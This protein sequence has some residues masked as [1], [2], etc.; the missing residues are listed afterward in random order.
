[1]R[2]RPER[3]RPH[4]AFLYGGSLAFAR[5]FPILALLAA[6]WLLSPQQFGQL[7][8][9]V[10]AVTTASLL[11]DSGT[12]SAATWHASRQSETAS[13]AR[14]LAALNWLRIAAATILTAGLTL[15]QI[16]V[17]GA[18]NWGPTIAAVLIAVAAN[19]LSARNGVHRVRLR[20]NGVGEPRSLLTE[21]LTGGLLF[22]ALVWPVSAMPEY[23]PVTYSATA[24]AGAL[25]V[26]KRPTKAE[27]STSFLTLVGF[28][29]IASPFMISALCAAV[30]WRA[31]TFVLGS[32]GDVAAAG[33]LAL[34]IYPI[35]LLTTVPVLTAPL[36]L[37]RGG[38]HSK[39]GRS[40]VALGA[41]IAFIASLALAGVLLI[42]I[43]W[44]PIQIVEEPVVV[45]LLILCLCIMPLWINPLVSSW[46][47]GNVSVWFPTL[48]HILGALV[49]IALVFPAA[50]G[51]SAAGAA[52]VIVTSEVT[53]LAALVCVAVIT[54]RGKAGRVE[55]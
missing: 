38:E 18:S 11:A 4:R 24:L 55:N 43:N 31:P 12:D 16:N 49:A 51:W 14:A 50:H 7:A 39:T 37:V 34:A 52:A 41:T 26:A 1:M 15:A 17:W 19:S 2:N 21:K 9:F 23:L 47:R 36:L 28:G 25:V 27:F 45:A 22:L 54:R 42:Y 8:I 3:P 48:T 30:V 32:L 35:Q 13:Q 6:S 10:T 5:A 20:I 29:R 33:Y 53:V 44:S 40:M 46:L